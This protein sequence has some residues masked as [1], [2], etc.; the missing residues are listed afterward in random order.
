MDLSEEEKKNFLAID[1]QPAHLDTR[2]IRTSP[3][4]NRSCA[5]QSVC[6][7]IPVQEHRIEKMIPV[8]RKLLTQDHEYL[9]Q[10]ARMRG[11]STTTWRTVELSTF[12]DKGSHGWRGYARFEVGESTRLGV[13][14][15]ASLGME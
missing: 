11:L 1:P 2:A 10:Y 3:P 8:T 7:P 12:L 14:E 5:Y 4:W 6:K 15:S 9:D 13:E